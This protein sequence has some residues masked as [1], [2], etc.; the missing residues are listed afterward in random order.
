LKGADI[1]T[2]QA[3]QLAVA[4]LPNA[5]DV[6]VA[7]QL[8][9]AAPDL[10]GDTAEHTTEPASTPLEADPADAFEQQLVYELDDYR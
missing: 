4:P 1:L 5:S 7:D 8:Q 3:A 10:D 2:E 6:D 9:P